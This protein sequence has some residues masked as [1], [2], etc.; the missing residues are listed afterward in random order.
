M[1]FSLRIVF[2][3][4]L[5]INSSVEAGVHSGQRSPT[6]SLFIKL[7]KEVVSQVMLC[8]IQRNIRYEFIGPLLL[9]LDLNPKNS[10]LTP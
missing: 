3:T 7:F 1:S 6:V 2:N 9:K 10:Y 5:A 4:R 8:F